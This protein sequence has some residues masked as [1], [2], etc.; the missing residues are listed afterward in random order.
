MGMGTCALGVK[1]VG[2]RWGKVWKIGELRLIPEV[3]NE[4]GL[5]VFYD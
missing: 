4:I 2:I 3:Q 1:G 5:V